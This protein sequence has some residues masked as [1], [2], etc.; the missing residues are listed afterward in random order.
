M[1]FL[2]VLWYSLFSYPGS[3]SFQTLSFEAVILFSTS[4]SEYSTF[5]PLFYLCRILQL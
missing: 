3:T 4:S 2:Y 5:Q 1:S